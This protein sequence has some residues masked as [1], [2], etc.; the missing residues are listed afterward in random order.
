MLAEG[1]LTLRPGRILGIEAGPRSA[2]VQV[3]PRGQHETV[4]IEAQRVIDATGIPAPTTGGDP[5]VR[6]LVERGLVRPD[7]HRLGL[8]VTDDLRAIG[9]AGAVS[10][11]LWALGPM[12]R[13]VF[14]ECTAVPDIRRQA[15]DLAGHIA[16][17]L[18]GEGG[19]N[20]GE[21]AA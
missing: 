14:W 15:L 13:G 19:V 12:V 7:R 6:R 2:R 17:S 21:R 9:A 5:F 3:R 4:V 16:R 10:P 8:D 20:G 1:W 11:G 18:G